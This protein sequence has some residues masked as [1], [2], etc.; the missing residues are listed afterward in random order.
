MTLA[1]PPADFARFLA[2]LKERIRVARIAAARSVN[3]ELISLYRDIGKAIAEKRAEAG[4]GDAVVDKL[5]RD[6]KREFPGTHGFSP[7]NLRRMEQFYLSYSTPAFLTLAARELGI[8]RG[9]EKRSQPVTKLLAA[10]PWGHHANALLGV[11]DPAARLYDLRAAAHFG[12]SRD[13]LINQIKANAYERTVKD[14]KTHNFALT[15]PPPLAGQAEE[16]LK[17]RYNLEF[18]GIGQAVKEAS[19]RTG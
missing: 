13:V 18:L 16:M 3:H 17:S 6:L 15:L 9:G 10:V 11:D 2:E 5:S 19:S 1:I 7:R 8:R 4:W 14:K 12:W